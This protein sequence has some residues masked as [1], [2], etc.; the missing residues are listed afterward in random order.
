MTDFAKELKEYKMFGP[1]GLILRLEE[2]NRQLQE[3]LHILK[4]TTFIDALKEI[5]TQPELKNAHTICVNIIKDVHSITTFS[6][7]FCDIENKSIPLLELL[8]E[9]RQKLYYLNID[10]KLFKGVYRCDYFPFTDEGLETF[11]AS[12]LRSDIAVSLSYSLLNISLDNKDN[13]K[14]KHKI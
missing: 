13:H 4:V 10:M 3:T 2:Q 9:L 7:S 5:K 1:K 12:L 11:K 14:T 8:E 6:L